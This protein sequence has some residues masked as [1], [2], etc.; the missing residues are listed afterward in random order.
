[1]CK[2]WPV[3]LDFKDG[4]KIYLLMSC[5]LTSYLSE[6]EINVMKKQMSGYTEEVLFCNG[7]KM[8]AE[9]TKKVVAKYEKYKMKILD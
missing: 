8:N 6:K 2:G 3:H 7:T 5:P 1:M 4:K 9:E